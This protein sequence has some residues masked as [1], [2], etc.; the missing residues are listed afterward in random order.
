ML[1]L[2]LSA[3]LWLL[4]ACALPEQGTDFASDVPAERVNAAARAARD[5]DRS[6][7][8]ELVECLDS[9][10]PGLR[11]IAA[12]TLTDLNK[13]ETFGYQHSIP[14]CRQPEAMKRWRAWADE[15]S[16]GTSAAATSPGKA[17]S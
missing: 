3:P 5:G 16:K 7:A 10:D 9:S 12:R 15:Q 17:S 2:T 14:G 6:K 11:F 4:A 13:G 1:F 8:R